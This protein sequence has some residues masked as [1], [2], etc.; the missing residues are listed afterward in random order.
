MNIVSLI[1]PSA[2]GFC[3]AKNKGYTNPISAAIISLASLIM[4]MLIS[5]YLP[6]M[7]ISERVQ[8]KQAEQALG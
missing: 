3:L 7:K 6:F 2:I 4:T 8:A 1:F 5:F